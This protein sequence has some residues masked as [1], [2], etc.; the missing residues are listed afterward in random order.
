MIQ[1]IGVDIVDVERIK[2]RITSNSGFCELVFSLE[3]IAYCTKKANPYESFAARFAAKEAF[4]KAVGTGIDFTIELKEI[5][6]LN[7]EFGKPYFK[8]TSISEQYLMTQLGYIPD[9][10]LSLS[11]TYQQAIAFVL[12]NKI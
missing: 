7:T 4:L 10:Q 9:I 5:Q 8:Q 1:G 3:E 6:V 11:H 12:F 2:Q